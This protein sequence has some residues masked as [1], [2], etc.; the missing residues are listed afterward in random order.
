[1]ETAFRVSLILSPPV[2]AARRARAAITCPGT[3]VTN[4]LDRI[5]R[6][7]ITGTAAS[8]PVWSRRSDTRS[9]TRTSHDPFQHGRVAS[10]PGGVHHAQRLVA[11]DQAGRGAGRPSACADRFRSAGGIRST[12]GRLLGHSIID[13]P[14]GHRTGSLDQYG[15]HLPPTLRLHRVI[16]PRRGAGMISPRSHEDPRWAWRSSSRPDNLMTFSPAPAPSTS[17]TNSSPR[18]R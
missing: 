2:P 7:E 9:A 13:V 6:R 11:Q 15:S 8:S 18:P 16:T 4:L 17:P 5:P 1:M 3:Q 14:N 10:R 12:R